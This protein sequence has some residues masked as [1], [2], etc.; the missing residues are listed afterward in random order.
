MV[1]VNPELKDKIYNTAFWPK[2][3][4]FGRFNFGLGRNFLDRGH[5]G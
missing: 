1:G 3:V 2:G 5:T 4:A